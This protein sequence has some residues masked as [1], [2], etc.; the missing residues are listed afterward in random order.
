[1]KTFEN[2]CDLR[3]VQPL[4]A[5]PSDVAKFVA[6]IAP[7]GID[8]VWPLVC[9]ISRAHYLRGLADPTQGGWVASA[10]NDIAKLDAPRSWPADRKADFARL[11]YDLQKFVAE[12]EKRQDAVVKAALQVAAEARKAADLPKLPK[13]FYRN[14]GNT[15]DGNSPHTAA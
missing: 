12:Q 5:V 15:A 13:S 14:K 10:I 4:P 8:K 7:L 9:E 1:M 2:W 3:N 6:D 11:P